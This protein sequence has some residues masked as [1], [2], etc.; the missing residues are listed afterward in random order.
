MGKGKARRPKREMGKLKG[1]GKRPARTHGV[2]IPI[3]NQTARTH[4]RTKRNGF[5]IEHPPI[6]DI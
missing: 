6:P 1:K 2:P 4:A 5:P 3:G